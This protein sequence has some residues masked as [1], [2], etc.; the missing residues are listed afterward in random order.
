[1]CGRKTARFKSA[2]QTPAMRGTV[3]RFDGDGKLVWQRLDNFTIQGEETTTSVCE[4]VTLTKDGG[5]LSVVD[6]GFGIGALVPPMAAAA[7]QQAPRPHSGAGGAS[8]SSTA[9]GSVGSAGA[10]R[11]G[12][13]DRNRQRLQPF[14]ALLDRSSRGCH[15]LRRAHCSRKAAKPALPPK[16]VEPY[17]VIGA[18]PS[19]LPVNS[20][21][22]SL[23]LR[24]A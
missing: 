3:T 23:V 17:F 8:G 14:V 13:N 2:L 7:G 12:R 24:L 18:A 20:V 4:Y 6:E 22:S 15:N 10:S 1:M 19:H 21:V 16:G 9:S 11:N 5:V